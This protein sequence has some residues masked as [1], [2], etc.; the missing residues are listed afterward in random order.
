MNG[1]HQYGISSLPAAQ[2]HI[3]AQG[4]ERLLKSVTELSQEFALPV[5][6]AEAIRFRDD[7]GIIQVVRVMLAKGVTGNS[8]S[9]EVVNLAIRQIIS[10]AVVSDGLLDVFEGAGLKDP[11]ISLLSD[12]FLAEVR[13]M[14]QRNLAEEQLQKLLKGEIKRNVLQ[15]RSFKE[16]LEKALQR[17]RQRAI[18]AARVIEELIQLAKD[19]Q[20]AASRGEALGL[21]DDEVA[22]YDAQGNNDSAVAV[23]CNNQLPVIPRELVATVKGRV[24]IDWTLRENVR[25]ELRVAV[26]RILRKYGYP[27]DLQAKA[28]D[29]VIEQAETLTEGW[30]VA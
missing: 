19:L 8:Q 7:V 25:A 18:E 13:G 17:C 9:D 16:L 10:K 12:E 21:N 4:K 20:A 22:F 3:L 30:A 29:T 6:N 24:T 15:A 26:K 28:N 5:P 14:P 27:P 2:E 1:T 23:L 11:D